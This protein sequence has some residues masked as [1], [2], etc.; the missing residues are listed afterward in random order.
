MTLLEGRK[1]KMPSFDE[2]KMPLFLWGNLVHF[3]NDV[4]TEPGFLNS[5]RVTCI[6]NPV[7]EQFAGD[8]Y[9]SAVILKSYDSI[10]V[11][12]I[13]RMMGMGYGARMKS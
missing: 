6:Q 12:K 1:I 8:V 13:C 10:V 4:Y 2:E 3:S 7:F 11:R 9:T 5:S